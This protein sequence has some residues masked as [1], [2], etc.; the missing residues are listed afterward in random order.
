MGVRVTMTGW[1][2]VQLGMMTM[3]CDEDD[4]DGSGWVMGWCRC[5][6]MVTGAMG[7]MGW[8]SGWTGQDGQGMMTDDGSG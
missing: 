5:R 6:W 7:A 2:T 3:R 1:V 4:E 8:V